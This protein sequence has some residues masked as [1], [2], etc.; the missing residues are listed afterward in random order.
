MTSSTGALPAS[1][2]PQEERN[3]AQSLATIGTSPSIPDPSAPATPRQSG[4][5]SMDQIEEPE[6]QHRIDNA[7]KRQRNQQMSPTNSTPGAV[8]ASQNQVSSSQQ[9]RPR[10][11]NNGPI[12][13][14]AEMLASL[15]REIPGVSQ[16]YQG[17]LQDP[18]PHQSSLMN[19]PPLLRAQMNGMQM[20]TTNGIQMQPMSG[21]Q[22]APSMWNPQG[23][24]MRMPMQ[25]G[26][27]P[28]G[29]AMMGMNGAPFAGGMFG[30]PVPSDMNLMYTGFAFNFSPTPP[31]GNTMHHGFDPFTM[32]QIGLPTQRPLQQHALPQ[33]PRRISQVP[34][35]GPPHVPRV[36][37]SLGQ[38]MPLLGDPMQSHPPI[39][40]EDYMMSGALQPELPQPAAPRKQQYVDLTTEDE[41]DLYSPPS[42]TGT[43]IH[44]PQDSASLPLPQIHATGEA[45]PPTLANSPVTMSN[46]VIPTPGTTSPPLPAST[47]ESPAVVV[48]STNEPSATGEKDQPIDVDSQKEWVAKLFV[49]DI[50]IGTL[51]GGPGIKLFQPLPVIQG[52]IL[53]EDGFETGPLNISKSCKVYLSVGGVVSTESRNNTNHSKLE[54]YSVKV[55]RAVPCREFHVRVTP[56]R[57]ETLRDGKVITAQTHQIARKAKDWTLKEDGTHE[58]VPPEEFIT[59]ENWCDTS[60]RELSDWNIA[61]LKSF[62]KLPKNANRCTNCNGYKFPKGEETS[63]GPDL[64]GCQ[65][66]VED[67]LCFSKSATMVGGIGSMGVLNKELERWQNVRWERI[68]D[69][70]VREK[71]EKLGAEMVKHIEAAKASLN[72][73]AAEHRE[74]QNGIF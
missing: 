22:M 54:N 32:P 4:K 50:Q 66:D 5:R 20:P 45:S 64:E 38:G 8:R 33:P 39:P 23:P 65:H 19:H 18:A 24:A 34:R 73:A 72:K 25:S 2:A 43:V 57:C 53:G 58:H 7:P 68:M 26:N 29:N 15:E 52:P 46:A 21:M 27:N 59:Y 70:A 30:A 49:N 63:L 55:P 6:T 16:E 13:S 51:A 42:S 67:F 35:P 44:R 40:P 62:P 37:P 56:G 14:A 10:M 41:D 69:G 71:A 11:A 61:Y 12:T 47:D 48:A 1:S 3:G 60:S 9:P 36:R 28:Y 31:L 74:R 17:Y